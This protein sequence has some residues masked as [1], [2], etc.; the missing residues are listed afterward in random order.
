[1]LCVFLCLDIAK[2]NARNLFFIRPLSHVSVMRIGVRSTFGKGKINR[3]GFFFRGNF[4]IGKRK[5]CRLSFFVS[6][7]VRKNVPFYLGPLFVH[8]LVLDLGV[9]H[10]YEFEFGL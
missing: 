10:H 4:A 8:G 1:M 9:E 7:R 5:F 2:S 6:R 3:L